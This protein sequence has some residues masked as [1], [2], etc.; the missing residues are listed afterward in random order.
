MN[1][2]SSSKGKS[3]TKVGES[4]FE[5]IKEEESTSTIHTKKDSISNSTSSN[6]T[7]PSKDGLRD[8]LKEPSKF[9]SREGGEQQQAAKR[10]STQ[11]V[12]KVKDVFNSKK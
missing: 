9:V 4:K 3:L 10:I 12:Y 11:N 6:T 1:V 2:V 7:K 8:S 5:E